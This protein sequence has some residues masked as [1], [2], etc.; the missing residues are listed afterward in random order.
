MR[1]LFLRPAGMTP[2]LPSEAFDQAAEQVRR[3]ILEANAT[4]RCFAPSN[5]DPQRMRAVKGSQPRDEPRHPSS[6]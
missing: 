6:S 2:Y 3:R 5:C 4:N 1:V